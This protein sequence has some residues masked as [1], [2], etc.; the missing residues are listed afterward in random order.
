MQVYTGEIRRA[1]AEVL[2]LVVGGE[3]GDDVVDGGE[4]GGGVDDNGS[5]DT[6]ATPP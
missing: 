1:E 5:T 6:L 3:P 4:V 2:E